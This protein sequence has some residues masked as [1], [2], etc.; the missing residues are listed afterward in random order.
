MNLIT[1]KRDNRYIE[2]LSLPTFT[3]FNMRSIWS[4]LSSL[5]EDMSEREADFSILSEVWE[6]KENM[7]HQKLI[8][9]V[10]EMKGM[11]YFSTARPGSKRGGGAA[12]TAKSD[13][14]NIT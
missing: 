7:E 12:I 1:I 6:C 8:E 4:K 3:V 13:K 14:F 10:F 9:E 5:A 2:A 11:K